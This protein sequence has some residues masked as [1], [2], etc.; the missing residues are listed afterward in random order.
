MFRAFTRPRYQVSV[1]RT[2][3]PLVRYSSYNRY[4]CFYATSLS[5]SILSQYLLQTKKHG[6]CLFI[7]RQQFPTLFIKHKTFISDSQACIHI[8]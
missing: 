2:I 4:H 1:Y 3:G 5:S 8:S 7:M 6:K